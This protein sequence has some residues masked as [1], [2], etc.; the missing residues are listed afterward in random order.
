MFFFFFLRA[1]AS[2]KAS[3]HQASMENLYLEIELTSRKYEKLGMVRPENCFP[4]PKRRRS[5]GQHF[6]PPSRFSTKPPP[7][8]FLFWLG[9]NGFGGFAAF[10]K[11]ILGFHGI[12]LGKDGGFPS[13]S[14]FKKTVF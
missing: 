10:L 11:E 8:E 9:L 5:R 1:F 12:F 14:C 6:H 7:L 2:K 3:E 4:P 13:P